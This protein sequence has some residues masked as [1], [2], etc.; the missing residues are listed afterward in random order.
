VKAIS[1]SV[2]KGITVGTL[3]TCA[4]NTGARVLKVIGVVGYKGVKR[5]YPKAGVADIVVASVKKG[6][7]DMKKKVVRAVVIRQRMPYRRANGRRVAFEDNAAVIINEKG[8]PKGSEVKGPV[9][10]EVGERFSKIV[11][12]AS[13]VV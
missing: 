12:I 1:A 8:E 6:T 2:T 13:I 7:P 10:K 3:L 9:A 5:R 4:D 11:R